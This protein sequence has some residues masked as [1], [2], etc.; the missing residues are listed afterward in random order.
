[1]K[2]NPRYIHVIENSYICA[3]YTHYNKTRAA[4]FPLNYLKTCRKYTSSNVRDFE[5]TFCQN[6]WLA[7]IYV[8][9][10]DEQRHNLDLQFLSFRYNFK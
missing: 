8:A 4:L 10:K 2:K 1:M 3:M 6:K 9:I 5:G 7:S